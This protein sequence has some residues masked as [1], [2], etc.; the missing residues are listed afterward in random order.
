MRAG[1]ADAAESCCE[2]YSPPRRPHSRLIIP[3]NSIIRQ[4]SAVSPSVSSSRQLS[5]RS[6]RNK[7][8]ASPS[9][10]WLT[11]LRFQ[12][13]MIMKVSSMNERHEQHYRKP[14]SR[15]HHGRL[16]D[17]SRVHGVG[18]A[19]RV[20]QLCTAASRGRSPRRWSR[21][22]IGRRGPFRHA[23]ASSAPVRFPRQPSGTSYHADMIS[24]RRSPLCS[25]WK[26][27]AR[28]R[29]VIRPGQLYGGA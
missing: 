4:I 18:T 25:G 27:D 28:A 24:N 1:C 7:R 20:A 22:R 3:L 11:W 6:P 10:T 15:N 13:W 14:K 29:H 12:A 8:G 26:A 17:S 5:A 21:I 2:I 19:S 23:G 9:T 16:N